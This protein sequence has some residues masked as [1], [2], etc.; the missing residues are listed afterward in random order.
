M[1]TE[2]ANKF[3]ELAELNA[4][5]FK[6]DSFKKEVA[7][8]IEYAVVPYLVGKFSDAVKQGRTYVICNQREIYELLSNENYTVDRNLIKSNFGSYHEFLMFA[9]KILL[10]K[11]VEMAMEHYDSYLND[12]VDFEFN[13]IKN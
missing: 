10:P 9:N 7:I 6:T 3:I 13:L 5:T 4:K 11:G 12:F 2:I 8:S 1:N